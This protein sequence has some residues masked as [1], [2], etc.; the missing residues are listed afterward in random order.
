MRPLK[1]IGV[2]CYYKLRVMDVTLRVSGIA[3]D[4]CHPWLLAV[5]GSLGTVQ[6][7]YLSKKAKLGARIAIVEYDTHEHA[8]H[9]LDRINSDRAYGPRYVWHAT[10]AKRPLPPR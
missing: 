2:E 3:D 10:W 5:F 6:R 9:A 4:L 8:V 7:L 1:L